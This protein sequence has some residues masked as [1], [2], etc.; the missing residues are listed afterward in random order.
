M[1]SDSVR[2]RP[3][4]RADAEA[5][6]RLRWDF[7]ASLAPP[8]EPADAF[9]ARCARWMADRLGEG[10][11]WRS[12]IADD[13]GAVR[14]QG[15]VWLGF[16]EKLPNPVGEPECHAYVSNLYVRPEARGRGLGEALLRAALAACDSRRVDAVILWPT[17]KSRS[18]YGRNGFRAVGDVMERRSARDESGAEAET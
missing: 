16:L 14:F 1:P 15:T 17:P 11:A 3:A 8:N 5:L 10:R 18:L 9:V 2:I 4:G 13:P 12:W 6:A 7:R